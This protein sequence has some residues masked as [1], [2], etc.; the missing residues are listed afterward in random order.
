MKLIQNFSEIKIGDTLKIKFRSGDEAIVK[1]TSFADKT[2][3][4]CDILVAS[5]G[6]QKDWIGIIPND[7]KFHKFYRL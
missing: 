6:V 5:S 2:H 7:F 3:I 1:V 4:Y